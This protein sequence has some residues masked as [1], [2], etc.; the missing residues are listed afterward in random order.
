VTALTFDTKL[1]LDAGTVSYVDPQVV[2][3]HD[4]KMEVLQGEG[5]LAD[6]LTFRCEHGHF[7]F[8]FGQVNFKEAT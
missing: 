3:E 1:E 6:H 7:T 4:C 8:P 5:H 2:V